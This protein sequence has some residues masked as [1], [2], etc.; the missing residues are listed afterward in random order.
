[1]TRKLKL[2]DS[3]YI[4]KESEEIYDVIFTGTRKTKKFMKKIT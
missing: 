4:M 1:M 2:K 3:I